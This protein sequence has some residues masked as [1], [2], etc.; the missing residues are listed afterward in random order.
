MMK[1]LDTKSY[2]TPITISIQGK[3][4]VSL[5]QND[6]ATIKLNKSAPEDERPSIQFVRQGNNID[7]TIFKYHG[8]RIVVDDDAVWKTIGLSGKEEDFNDESI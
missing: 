3:N 1:V 4:K 2:K 5:D 8:V 7:I 6:M